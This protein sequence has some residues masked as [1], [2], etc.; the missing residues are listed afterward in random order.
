MESST[1]ETIKKFIPSDKIFI[2]VSDK[3]G[4][5]IHEKYI[6]KMQKGNKKVCLY[7]EDKKLIRTYG[8]D[9]KN[10]KCILFFIDSFLTLP[11]DMLKNES[12]LM[13]S[14]KNGS[15]QRGMIVLGVMR[16]LQY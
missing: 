2:N 14:I 6:D 3:D 5:Y 13:L 9:P 11:F 8:Y 1:F 7:S 12:S 4:Q 10:Y 15:N 16:K